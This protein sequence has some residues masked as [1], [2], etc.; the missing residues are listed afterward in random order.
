MT[1]K[2]VLATSN[3]G[4]YEEF[5]VLLSGS[6]L[7][8]EPAPKEALYGVEETG[9][10]F[11]E[12]ALIKARAVSKFC[13]LPSL[14]DDSG[15]VVDALQ[16]APGIHSARFAGCHGDDSANNAK[17]LKL[18]T[19]VTGRTAK[20]VC[21]LA[22]LQYHS[23]PEPT[24][25]IGEWQGALAHTPRG[26]HGFGYDPLFIDTE[27]NQTAAELDPLLK[28]QRSHRARATQA[29]IEQISNH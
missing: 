3:K 15:L 8:I 11:I 7:E 12:N 1:T 13:D 10:S 2:V 19:D 4:K 23:D 17:L 26:R 16:G 9:I 27:L 22:F 14:A 25:A 20:F 5:R 6:N 18:M 29:L 28:N 24:I 21:V